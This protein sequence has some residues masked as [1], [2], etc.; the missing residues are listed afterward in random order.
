MTHQLRDISNQFTDEQIYAKTLLNDI[1]KSSSYSG[2]CNGM[3][4]RFENYQMSVVY[5]RF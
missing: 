5:H 3:I 4:V 1:G 2:D